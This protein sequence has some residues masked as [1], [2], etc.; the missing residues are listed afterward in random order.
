MFHYFLRE[1]P[2]F[3]GDESALAPIR[4]FIMRGG[5]VE[6]FAEM[7]RDA[8]T[9]D[10]PPGATPSRWVHVLRVDK[11]Y[12]AIR[13]KACF[14]LGPGYTPPTWSVNIGRNPEWLHT[15]GTEGIGH[16]FVYLEQDAQE[17]FDGEMQELHRIRRS[18]LL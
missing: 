9:H 17:G 2:Q 4:A 13:G 14:F 7:G 15:P 12:M 11:D 1:F 16:Q 8:I 10:M 6:D 3:R 18:L 5:K